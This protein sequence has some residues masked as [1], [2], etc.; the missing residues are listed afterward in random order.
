MLLDTIYEFPL[1]V[2]KA[3]GIFLVKKYH[4]IVWWDVKEKYMSFQEHF[5]LN[6]DFFPTIKPSQNQKDTKM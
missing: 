6:Q 4:K 5:S 1:F 2:F 3:S